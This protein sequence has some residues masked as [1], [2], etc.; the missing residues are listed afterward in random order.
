MKEISYIN[1]LK[2][3]SKTAATFLLILVILFAGLVIPGSNASERKNLS[4]LNRPINSSGQTGIATVAL[5][6]FLVGDLIKKFQEAASRI[7]FEAQ[8][9]GDALMSKF[10][11][12]LD[13]AARNLNYVFTNQQNMFFEQLSVQQQQAF[14]ELNRMIE[15]ANNLG[16]QVATVAELANL[17]LINFINQLPLTKK[18]KF[19][20]SS[21]NGQTIFLQ[22][23]DFRL[24]IRGLGFGFDT[25]K[26]RY[27]I[28]FTV[29][30]SVLPDTSITRSNTHELQISIPNDTVINSFSDT[31]IAFVPIKFESEIM[32]KGLTGWKSEKYHINF[33]LT[34]LPKLAGEIRIVES[35][36]E[37]VLDGITKTYDL[38]RTVSG[39]KPDQPCDWDQ[40]HSVALDERITA[41]RYDCT[42]QC[43]HS[44]SLRRRELNAK[45]EEV[46]P[47]CETKAQ[48]AYGNPTS[49][50][51]K[52]IKISVINSCMDA[53]AKGME[54]MPDFD[55]LNGNR[56]AKVYRHVDGHNSTTVIHHIDYQTL[57]DKY[58]KLDRG[59]LQIPFN[60]PFTIDFDTRNDGCHYEVTGKL[61]TKQVINITNNTA[62]NA[63]N[64]LIATGAGPFGDHC[65]VTFVLRTP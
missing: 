2:F 51:G 36:K 54:Y 52:L 32:T 26:Q 25:D 9:T 62:G 18:V 1:V 14:I 42:G 50:M 61:V 16:N 20:V 12:Q 58:S 15:S 34:L 7:L 37:R 5:G 60:Q 63:G 59:T 33:N 40:E 46:R 4:D 56:T 21:I 29:G 11:N 41:V 35:I 28:K 19:Y 22:E 31:K 13:V 27:R 39:C 17:D 38:S 47:D 55:I 6:G 45:R 10:G 44:Y 30:Q 49:P 8:N 43:S 24:T 65:R 57:I 48:Q 23:N 64:L 53:A 3:R